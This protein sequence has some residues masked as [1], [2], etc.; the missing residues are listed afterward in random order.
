M[1]DSYFYM[2]VGCPGEALWFSCSQR[3]KLSWLSHISAL[4]VADEGY[5]LMNVV[6]DECCT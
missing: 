4:S 3:L 6:P 2:N 5:Y 1:V